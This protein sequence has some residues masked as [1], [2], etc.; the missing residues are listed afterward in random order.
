MLWNDEGLPAGTGGVT[1]ERGMTGIV[2]RYLGDA[3]KA[4]RFDALRT[5]V[6]VDG[7]VALATELA[8]KAEIVAVAEGETL[9]VQ[10]ADDNDLYLIIAGSFSINVNGRRLGTRGRNE[11]VGEMALI[12]PTQRRSATVIA[13]DAAVVAKVSYALFTDLVGRYP[14]MYRPIARTLAQRLRERNKHVGAH[15]E[16]IKVFIISSSEAAEVAQIIQESFEHTP[17]LP[18]LWADGVFRATTYAL[19][20]LEK[21][22]DE[23]DF[24]VA[25]AHSDDITHFRGDTWPAPRDNVVF[26]LGMFL[27]RLGRSRAILMEPRE[28]RV[29]LPSDMSGVTTIGYNFKAGPNAVALMAPACTK[30]K[31]HIQDTGPFNG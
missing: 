15:R 26:E 17:I 19:E 13:E 23:C 22:V 14:A 18:I 1:R 11:H 16:T 25:V 3:A 7:D 5:Q 28:D 20:A 21:A 8:D 12:E 4:V 9:I 31:R 29:K 2:D 6:M 10:D 24:A 30:L 27:G